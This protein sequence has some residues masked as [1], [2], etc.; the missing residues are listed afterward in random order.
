VISARDVYGKAFRA[1]LMPDPALKVSEWADRYR[2]IGTSNS[3]HGRWR[4]ARTPYLVEVMD[5]LSPSSS[6]EVV[7]FMKGAQVGGTE[8]IL[9]WIGYCIDQ[10]PGP[11]LCVMPREEDARRYSKEKIAPMIAANPRLQAKVRPARSRDS[12]NRTLSKDFPG[13]PMTLAGAN[14][15]AALRFASVRYAALDELD[16]YQLDVEGEGDPVELVRA[17]LRNWMRKKMALVSTPTIQGRSRIE[18]A[19]LMT[20]QRYYHVPCPAC[21]HFQ[22]LE[23]VHLHYQDDDPSTVTY[24]CVECGYAIE[25]HHKEQMLAAGKWVA[26]AE[27]G[28]RGWVG[29]HLS[30]L[31]SPLGWFS[32]VE[33]VEQW[34][35]ARR[36]KD[37][38]Q[39]KTFLNTVLGETWKEVGEAP[40]W[41]P[42]Y[43]RREAYPPG[44]VPRGGL[45]IT[46]GVDVQPDRIEAMVVAWGRGME[47]WIVDYVVLPG[48]VVEPA[49][50]ADLDRLI[51]RVYPHAG[52][53]LSPVRQVGVDSGFATTTVYAWAVHHSQR[54]VAVMD[55][56]Q[57]LQTPVGVARAVEVN[58]QGKRR[59]RGVRLY[60]VG[61]GL[62]KAQLYGWLRHE[63][64]IEGPCPPGFCH[65]PEF[66]EEFFQQLT[67][68]SLVPK[69]R[70]GHKFTTTSEWAKTR[71]RNEALDCWVYA[72]AAAYLAGVD[73]YEERHWREV[74]TVL[75]L[76]EPP[77]P[78]DDPGRPGVAGTPPAPGPGAGGKTRRPGYF[79][80]WRRPSP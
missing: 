63:K 40:P 56:R 41:R 59:R 10:A 35:E 68:E 55:G 60:P 75:G 73:R 14:S 4:N 32:W 16:A 57:T 53:G 52:G 13:G 37:Q 45:V 67:A 50:W 43:D 8:C 3:E 58:D 11:I 65:F 46:M 6:S 15:A 54:Q 31:Y 20:D 19:F 78:K 29:F 42:L 48:K 49:V 18:A 47:H 72:R 77:P 23:W 36:T 61:T 34:L 69:I 25:E 12:G 2:V 5:E 71:E 74:E 27:T 38:A 7:V 62:L 70:R 64:P 79:D 22:R 9:N 39:L 21:G 24:G 26:S 30:S 76:A 1:G 33:V 17:R 44:V 66:G 80:R 28:R 51:G